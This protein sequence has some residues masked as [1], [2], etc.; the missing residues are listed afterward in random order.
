MKL[1]YI[2]HSIGQNARFPWEW[3]FKFINKDI[4]IYYKL[5]RKAKQSPGSRYHVTLGISNFSSSGGAAEPP[6]LI[7]LHQHLE[8]TRQLIPSQPTRCLPQRISSPRLA[9]QSLLCSLVSQLQRPVSIE[10]RRSL[11][12]ALSKPLMLDW[13]MLYKDCINRF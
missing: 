10:K 2:I 4:L 3:M 5:T 6:T 7:H 8:H 1:P 9:T 12:V 11:D 13:G